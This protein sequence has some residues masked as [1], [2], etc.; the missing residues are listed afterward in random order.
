MKSKHT[1][2]DDT[3]SPIKPVNF[4]AVF[5]PYPSARLQTVAVDTPEDAAAIAAYLARRAPKPRATRAA[6]SQ[7]VAQTKEQKAKAA[8][9]RSEAKLIAAEKLGNKEEKRPPQFKVWWKM[10]EIL[11]KAGE[12]SAG[13]A[14]PWVDT[15]CQ[16]VALK[17]MRS[18]SKN[19]KL[20]AQCGKG[21]DL[22]CDPV[23]V[24]YLA[25]KAKWSTYDPAKDKGGGHEAYLYQT[26]SGHIRNAAWELFS[27]SGRRERSKDAPPLPQSQPYDPND[28][29][30][31]EPPTA[32]GDWN[33]V[34]V[35]IEVEQLLAP[36]VPKNQEILTAAY[37]LDGREKISI[38]TLAVLNGCSEAALRKR[39]DRL[40]KEMHNSVSFV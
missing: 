6:N 29:S 25:A 16:W 24:G 21:F 32:W 7:K 27:P 34:D 5:S 40:K 19:G 35:T 28:A 39:I 1:A 17:A 13:K 38:A 22:A 33:M 3:A 31:N 14:Y 20:P 18:L 10:V 15:V 4:D 12:A 37:G 2:T 36:L 8:Y 23:S 9:A 11:Y 26:A 30:Q